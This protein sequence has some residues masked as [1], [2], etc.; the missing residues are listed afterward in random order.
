MQVQQLAAEPCDAPFHPDLE[1]FAEVSVDLGADAAVSSF[2]FYQRKYLVRDAPLHLDLKIFAEVPVSD[3][4]ADAVV[5]SFDFCQ[6]K[7]LV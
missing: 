6:R 2:D 3:L 7:Y 5:S 1:T 4:G